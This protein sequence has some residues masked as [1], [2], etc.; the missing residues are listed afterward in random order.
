[1]ITMVL[2][3]FWHGAG[4]TFILWGGLH[5]FYLIV[6]HAWRAIF[7]KRKSTKLSSVCGW[8]ITFMVVV[9]SWV[10]FRAESIFGA[11]NLLQAM[12]GLNGIS[13]WPSL[14]KNIINYDLSFSVNLI[15]FDGMFQNSLY[16]NNFAAIFWIFLLLLMSIFFPNTQQLMRNHKS[17]FE[18]YTGEVSRW[19]H[20][21][22][23]WEKTTSWALL[24]S[25]I[26]TIS[27]LSMSGESEFLYF[28]F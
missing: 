3:G 19:S 14:G 26:L 24:T 16:A 9:V 23:E 20:N 12:A 6:N 7:K 5:G 21:W 10:P 11:K 13:L 2:G 25:I 17:A 22:I 4:W 8:A 1:M 27:I 15:T 28:Q 18:T